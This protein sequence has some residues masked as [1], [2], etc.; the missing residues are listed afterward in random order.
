MAVAVPSAGRM[1]PRAAGACGERRRALGR[2][3][4]ARRLRLPR[5]RRR[6]VSDAACRSSPSASSSARSSAL[7]AMGLVLVYRA[8]RIVNFAQGDLG[9]LA[10]IL[11]ASLIVGPRWAFFPAAAVGPASPR[12]SSAR[13]IE[14]LHHPP[15][16]EGAAA[17]PH[18]RDDRRR[19]ALR[20]RPARP[21]EAVRLRHRPAAAAAVLLHASV[22]PRHVQRRAHPDPGR[23]ADRASSASAR[24]SASPHRHRHPGVGR[25]GRPRRAARHPGE[26][27]RH[28]RL[29]HRRR[30]VRP[31][32]CCCACRSRAWPSAPCSAR[33]CC[34]GRWPPPSS[35][36]WRAC[37]SPFGAALVL[38]MV[39]QAVF[40]ETRPHG[41]R[42]RRAVLRHHRRAAAPAPRRRG[43]GPTTAARRRGRPPARCA[44]SRA[45]SRTAARGPLSASTCSALLVLGLLALAPLTVLRRASSTCSS[46]GLDL[47]HRHRCRW[48]SS[49]GMGRPDQPRPAARSSRSACRSPACSRSGQGLLRHACSPPASSAPASRW[50]SACPRC[51]SG[52]CSWR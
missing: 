1:S 36:A 29:G 43:R 34:C 18:R 48:W 16:R 31:R 40:F 32:P 42:R 47:R 17:D 23:R 4:R 7:V 27:H 2:W 22:G 52:A 49:P 28:A 10:A 51:A 9:G 11:A 12:S 5:V 8:N 24:S 30:P 3:T 37:P 39:E 15:V 21:A 41:R 25:V 50:P 35:A 45:S 26:A 38:G 6:P 44:R 19:P 46:V 33:R 20:V 14:V 13:W